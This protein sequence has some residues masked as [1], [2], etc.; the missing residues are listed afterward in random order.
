MPSRISTSAPPMTAMNWCARISSRSGPERVGE[1]D[2]EAALERIE[3]EH[4]AERLG[5]A[6]QA[7]DDRQREIEQAGGGDA[8]A[9]HREQW[10]RVGCVGCG[11]A[12]G[13]RPRRARIWSRS[14][15]ARSSEMVSSTP[16]S[17]LAPA[18][19]PVSSRTRARPNRR[20][21]GPCSRSTSVTRSNGMARLVRDRK[22]LSIR[23][24]SAPTRYSSLSQV[25]SS[26][27]IE[28]TTNGDRD[29]RDEPPAALR[30]EHRAAGD[31]A[32]GALE[33]LAEAGD[34]IERMKPLGRAERRHARLRAALGHSAS[35]R[36]SAADRLADLGGAVGR[37]AGQRDDAVVGAG[38]VD[39]QA[40]RCR[41]SC[42]AGRA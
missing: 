27:P 22:P 29:Q 8:A 13:A 34:E 33:R 42:R 30:A 37:Q 1:A 2:P 21:S 31:Q 3:A 36:I 16:S 25:N 24:S 23:S 4:V 6:E 32:P 39:D 7:G 5:D 26:E 41:T 40:W 17:S 35:A 20:W 9:V 19:A 18:E 15:S 11:G 28:K 14:A 12:S 10:R 38:G